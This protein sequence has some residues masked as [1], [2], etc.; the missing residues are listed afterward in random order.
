MDGD[1]EEEEEGHDQILD[2]KLSLKKNVGVVAFVVPHQKRKNENLNEKYDKLLGVLM[3]LWRLCC[4]LTAE[5]VDFGRT[6]PTR[7]HT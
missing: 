7:L 3:P 4:Q 1:E 2:L 5:N 6:L